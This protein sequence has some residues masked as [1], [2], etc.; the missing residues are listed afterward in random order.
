MCIRDRHQRP[1]GARPHRAIDQKA[2][3]DHEAARHPSRPIES[4]GHSR[5]RVMNRTLQIACALMVASATARAQAASKATQ[6]RAD[7][8]YRV[9]RT[10]IDNRDYRRAETVL[11]L[12][13]TS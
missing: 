12:L 9:G 3:R 8:L 5:M 13:Y 11:C 6:D 10:A 1:R 4:A 2:R 7:S